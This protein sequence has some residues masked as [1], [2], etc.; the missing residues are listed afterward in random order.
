MLEEF[1][2]CKA[3]PRVLLVEVCFS[4]AHVFLLL[5]ILVFPKLTW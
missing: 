5:R 3:L 4:S 1:H 2:E